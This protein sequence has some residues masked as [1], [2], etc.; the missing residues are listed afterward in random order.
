MSDLRASDRLELARELDRRDVDV[1]ARLDAVT[2]VLA[3]VDE[4]RSRAI[5][6]RG[7]LASM[8]EEIEHAERDERDARARAAELRAELDE[9]DRR[10]REVAGSRRSTEDARVQAQRALSRA[11]VAAGDAETSA[12]RARAR[13]EQL[14]RD[15]ADAQAEGEGLAAGA[16]EVAQAVA[17]IPRVS[18]SG[19]SM[20]GGSLDEIEEWGARAHAALFVVRGSL[21]GERERLVAE[22]NGLAAVTLGDQGG[23]AS[24]ALVR[25]R[26]EDWASGS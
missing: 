19:R 18:D 14:V 26:I 8:P 1:A 17:A 10:L 24:V 6:V 5:W 3:R 4:I 23:A 25:R 9:A 20:P 16:R 13:L 11:T 15:E 21:E 7:V 22:A 12:E 2:A